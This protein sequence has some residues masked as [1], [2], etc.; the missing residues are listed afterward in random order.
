M[1]L[2]NIC[3]II[4]NNI[5]NN[6]SIV[7]TMTS[8]QMIVFNVVNIVG[9]ADADGNAIVSVSNV[10]ITISTVTTKQFVSLWCSYSPEHGWQTK[11]INVS[12]DIEII[13]VLKQ[14]K[15]ETVNSER[16]L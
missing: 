15:T 6:K 3:A 11:N 12:L 1:V 7:E 4:V 2:V 8:E 10:V 13:S 14:K 9:C 5:Q 16:I